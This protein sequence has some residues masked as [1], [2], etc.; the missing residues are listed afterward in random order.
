MSEQQTTVPV[1]LKLLREAHAVMR[2]CGWQLAPASDASEDPTLALAA[3]EIEGAFRDLLAD[4][5]A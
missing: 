1:P 5:K 3:A 2:A 4:V